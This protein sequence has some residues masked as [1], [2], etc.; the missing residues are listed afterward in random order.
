MV[1][2]LGVQ[3]RSWAVLKFGVDRNMGLD[4][5]GVVLVMYVSVSLV[6]GLQ[7]NKCVVVGESVGVGGW[8]MPAQTA[9][10]ERAIGC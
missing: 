10:S 7:K 9:I 6:L 5:D 2:S 1:V 4:K 3:L 8:G